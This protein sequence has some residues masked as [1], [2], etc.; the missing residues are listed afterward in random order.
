MFSNILFG[1]YADTKEEIESFR[2]YL[3]TK[4]VRFL[5][6]QRVIS[7]HIPRQSFAFVPDL[8]HYSGKYSDEFLIKEWGITDEEWQ[9]IDERIKDVSEINSDD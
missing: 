8:G 7:Q 9:L 6:S 2:T 1:Y 5:L 3:F 4:T